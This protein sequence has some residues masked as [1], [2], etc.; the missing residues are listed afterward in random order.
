[1]VAPSEHVVL[2]FRRALFETRKTLIFDGSL[3]NRIPNVC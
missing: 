1:M 2:V 3:P